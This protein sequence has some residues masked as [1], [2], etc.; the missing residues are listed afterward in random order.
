MIEHVIFDCFGT[1][2]DSGTGSV[3]ATRRILASV[4]LDVDP[5]VFYAE[6]KKQ[7]KKLMALDEFYSEKELFAISL[8]EMFAYNGVKADAEIEVL[9]MI[10]ILFG[11]RKVFPDTVEALE[12]LDEMDID[13][14]IGSTTDT[15]SLMHFLRQ[16]DLKFERIFTSEDMKV[17]KP[18]ERFFKTIL[19]KTG[20]D[21]EECLYVGD[22][23]IDDVQGP[24]SVGM[25]AALLDRRGNY[26]NTE[27]IKPDYVIGS[28][29][30]IADI[31]KLAD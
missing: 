16:N 25:K 5:K 26:R 28:L 27:E 4:G 11:E 2:I 20:W 23:L 29:I 9:P 8:A 24:Q 18:N 1:L 7:K 19:E 14:A 6:W 3:D 12:L 10:E 22:T 21:A 30:E 17:Y 13:Y 15:D 31:V